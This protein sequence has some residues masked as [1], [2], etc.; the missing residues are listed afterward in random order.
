MPSCFKSHTHD[1]SFSVSI[2]NIAGRFVLFAET[3]SLY[4]ETNTPLGTMD[5]KHN[6]KNLYMPTHILSPSLP[7]LPSLSCYKA[8][9]LPYLCTYTFNY[10]TMTLYFTFSDAFLY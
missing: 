8:S 2:C 4:Q 1:C 6:K 9:T 5:K 10:I 3:C 7:P